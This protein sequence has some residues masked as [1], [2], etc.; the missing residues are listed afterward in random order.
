VHGHWNGT[1]VE[2][3]GGD[4]GAWNH[5]AK[6]TVPGKEKWIDR[7]CAFAADGELFGTDVHRTSRSYLDGF[8][9]AV[10]TRYS[11]DDIQ[12]EEEVFT[13]APDDPLYAQA[14]TLRVSNSGATARKP[15][16]S[17]VMGRRRS[18]VAGHRPPVSGPA[19]GPLG[20]EPLDTGYQLE[21]DHQ[22]IRNASGEVVLYAEQPFLEKGPLWSISSIIPSTSPKGRRSFILSFLPLT[23]R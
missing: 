1:I 13:T 22:T 5:G 15:Q 18:A 16:V 2:V 20:F 8:M 14:V 17:L 9:P 10:V 11:K 7:W 19:L 21:P 4:Q 12:F 3:E 6:E 23:S